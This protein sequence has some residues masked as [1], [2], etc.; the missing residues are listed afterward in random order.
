[1][2]SCE[3]Y[4][5]GCTFGWLISELKLLFQWFYESI[6]GGFASLVELIP[7]P[8]FMTQIA[9]SNFQLPASV[10]YWTDY[11]QLPFGMTVITSAITAR[12]ILRRIPGIG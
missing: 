2:E 12:F 1:M 7:A 5:V 3:W 4:D 9:T 8:D 6:L 11:F 10:I